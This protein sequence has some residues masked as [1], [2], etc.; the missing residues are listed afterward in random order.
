MTLASSRVFTAVR[1]RLRTNVGRRFVR[2]VPVAIASFAVSETVVF[3]LVWVGHVTAG[4]SGLGGW[5]SG[6]LVSY[7]LS[8]WAWERRGRPHLLKETLPFWAV[9]VGAAVVLST[10]S[11]FAGVWAASIGLS[12]TQ[13]ALF[14]AGAYF[15]ANCFTFTSRFLI[16]HYVLFA[17]RGAKAAL[18]NSASSPANG[19]AGAEATGFAYGSGVRANGA[20]VRLVE[21]SRG[22][23][24]GEALPDA[25]RRP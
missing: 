16:F 5:L 10:T 3:S 20:S 7:V 18:G 25:G 9:S 12:H 8:R 14:V 1:A 11:H 15:V 24:D 2:F 22:A 21:S 6:A 13:R 17:D 4:L 23:A 19:S